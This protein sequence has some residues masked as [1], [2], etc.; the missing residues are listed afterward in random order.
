[1]YAIKYGDVYLV[2]TEYGSIKTTKTPK[3]YTGIKSAK[4]AL[5]KMVGNLTGSIEHYSKRIGD[6]ETALEKAEKALVKHRATYAELIEQPYKLVADKVKAVNSK[7]YNADRDA[8]NAKYQ[9]TDARRSIKRWQ[10]ALAQNP[11]IV[12]FGDRPLDTTDA[13][14]IL[15]A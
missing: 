3:L 12:V 4:A 2:S 10:K 7:I 14:E 15:K 6:L 5:D 1:M 13:F 8:Y 9:L 11:H